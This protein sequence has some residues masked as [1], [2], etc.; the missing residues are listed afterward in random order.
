MIPIHIADVLE[1]V[2]LQPEWLNGKASRPW[3][4]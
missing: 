1:V 4:G 2:Y 3:F